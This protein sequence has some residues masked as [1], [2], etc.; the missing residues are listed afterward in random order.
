MVYTIDFLNIEHLELGYQGQGRWWK[1]GTGLP[2]QKS[3]GSKTLANNSVFLESTAD[4]LLPRGPSFKWNMGPCAEQPAQMPS[5][6]SLSRS[7]PPWKRS[8]RM[9]Y[10][11][12]T[13]LLYIL[14]PMRNGMS[15]SWHRAAL[16]INL[17]SPHPLYQ[18][19]PF[20]PNSQNFSCLHFKGKLNLFLRMAWHQ[21]IFICLSDP[22]FF[23]SRKTMRWQ[24][25]ATKT[26]LFT[27]EILVIFKD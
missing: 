6:I 13:C 8:P 12:C 2:G 22:A 7:R 16:R 10:A 19:L 4:W 1:W 20:H 3:P 11:L 17:L 24:E 18:L 5:C 21:L 23:I 14:L 15:Q 25:I 9:S 26:D 27:L